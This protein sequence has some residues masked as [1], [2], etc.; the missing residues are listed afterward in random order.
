MR[1]LVLTFLVLIYSTLSVHSQTSPLRKG[2][3]HKQPDLD[4]F[5]G[6]WT[7]E[8]KET[9]FQLTIVNTKTPVKEYFMDFVTGYYTYTVNGKTIT[10]L[11]SSDFRPVYN[12]VFE[13]A[14]SSKD[15]IKFRFRDPVKHISAVGWMSLQDNKLKWEISSI[16]SHALIID[17]K[18]P[19][20][21]LSIPKNMLLEKT[22]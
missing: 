9:K 3:Y 12:G 21:S 19:D 18:Q 11:S 2:H 8:N 7:Y 16:Q 13:K 22:L 1:T 20:M 17:G 15:I 6:T 10:N 4:R 14:K 5:V